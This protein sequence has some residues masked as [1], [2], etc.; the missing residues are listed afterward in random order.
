MV[1]KQE[2][3]SLLLGMMEEAGEQVNIKLKNEHTL[4]IPWEL[5]VKG[6][7]L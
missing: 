4:I 6:R 2:E 3:P 5:S 7:D 1:M